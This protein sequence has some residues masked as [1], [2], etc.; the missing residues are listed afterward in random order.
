MAAKEHEI[1]TLGIVL[2]GNFNT[3]IITPAWLAS[4]KLIRDIEAETAKIH[5]I[6]PDITRFEIDWLSF[7]ATQNRIDFKTNQES[8]FGVLRDLV[9]SIFGIL[10]E[11][12][13]SAFG[14]NHLCHYSLKNL[15]EYH[16]FGY[17]LSP[18]QEFAGILNNP[19]VL[20]V[21]YIETKDSD[22]EDNGVIR[23]IIN[24]SDLINDNKSVLLACNHHFINS[25]KDAKNM[26]RLISEIWDYSFEKTKNLNDLIWSKAKL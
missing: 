26:T 2:L 8:H 12:P 7:E 21:E 22:K 17:W 5:V 1:Y 15:E 11:T 16:N 6:H 13:I 20:S 10:K 25:N 14:V 24:P 19:K 23:L 3:V 4:K 18:V 9:I